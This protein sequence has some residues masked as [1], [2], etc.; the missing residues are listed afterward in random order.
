MHQI[1]R[2]Y[3]IYA[4]SFEEAHAFHNNFCLC[5]QAIFFDSLASNAPLSY[6]F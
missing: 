6:L 2:D 4:T 1:S 3:F 5:S